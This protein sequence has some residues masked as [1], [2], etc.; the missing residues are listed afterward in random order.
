[1]AIYHLSVKTI[2]RSSGRSATA[3]AAYRAGEEIT[4]ERTG[5]VH[6]YTRRS[7]VLSA[8]L[9]LPANAPAWASDRSA[10]WNAAEK[11]ETRK[12]S[13]V[14]REFEV[15]LPDELT[16]DQRR[17]LVAAFAQ[18]IADR[19]GV[20]VDAAIHAPD[21]EGDKRN[22]HAHVLT[23]TRRLGPD[24]FGEKARELDDRKTG[25]ELVTQ[26]R[27]RWGDLTN[28]A[29]QNAGRSERV[30]HRTLKAQHAEAVASLDADRA[31]ELDRAP[32][33]KLGPVPT[34]DLRR[35]E[36]TK[37][38]PRTE[39]VEKWREVRAE[40]TE[41]RSVLRQW[42]GSLRDLAHD[43][44]EAIREAAEKIRQGIAEFQARAIAWMEQQTREQ[45]RLQAARVPEQAREPGTE[46]RG[47]GG[48]RWHDGPEMQR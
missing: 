28:R 2:S 29:L 36:R 25:P 15:A 38:A 32:G 10:L 8:D 1:M 26:W 14:A 27:E 40:N 37:E 46:G 33:I 42:R 24:G 13:T 41:R 16:A 20:A 21:R 45:A 43:G 17:Q 34:L 35:S 11:S 47:R 23:S 30:D 3:A 12:N 5:E 44:I 48:G 18:E 4:D 31:D 19:H 22:H 6:D 39:R 9:T 7:G